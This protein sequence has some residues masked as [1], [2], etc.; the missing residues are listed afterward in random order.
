M[1][2]DNFEFDDDNFGEEFQDE[3]PRQPQQQPQPQQPRKGNLAPPR[4]NPQ[5][6]QRNTVQT[7]APASAPVTT[8]ERQR[9]SPYILPA[10]T[11]VFDNLTNKPLMEDPEKTD[12]LV[13]LL[14]DV[15]N[16]LDR[17]EQNL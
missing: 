14:T 17:I 2:E 1:A 16:R 3:A 6:Q 15:I 10:R 13:A 5:P 4:K 12:L 8:P 7:Q 9:Y 11:G